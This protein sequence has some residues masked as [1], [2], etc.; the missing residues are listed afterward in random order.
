MRPTRKKTANFWAQPAIQLEGK[1][2]RPPHAR[3]IAAKPLLHRAGG[4][5]TSPGRVPISAGLQIGRRFLMPCRLPIAAQKMGRRT[6][7]KLRQQSQVRRQVVRHS[8]HPRPMSRSP[9]RIITL[10]KVMVRPDRRCRSARQLRIGDRGARLDRPS[11]GSGDKARLVS[12]LDPRPLQ[13]R[14][15]W[16]FVVEVS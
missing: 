7:T 15:L 1:P 12:L 11:R 13:I 6:R 3:S 8:L 4:P 10:T 16:K 9:D 2:T 14:L 5:T